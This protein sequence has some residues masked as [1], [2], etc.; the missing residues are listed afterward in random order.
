MKYHLIIILVCFLA[1]REGYSQ[2]KISEAR[3]EIGLFN[4]SK[5]AAILQPLASASG[6]KTKQEAALL[7]A[8]CY[9]M[10]NDLANAKIWYKNALENDNHQLHASIQPVDWYY[11]AQAARSCGEYTLAKSLFLHFDSLVPSDGRGRRFAGFCDSVLAWQAAKPDF[12]VRNLGTLNSPQS[13]FGAVLYKDGV[14]FVSDRVGKKEPGKTYGWT[15]N[16]YLGLYMAKPLV[17]DSLAG[18]YAEPGTL[19]DIPGHEWHEGPVSFN[20]DFSE[21]FI[22]RTLASHDKGKKETGHVR[23]HLLKIFISVRKNGQWQ[24]PIPFFLNSD[25]YSVGHPSL[26]PDGQTL[27]FVSDMKGG[28]GETDIWYCTREGDH[29]S[30]PHNP[31]AAVNTPGKEM[32]PFAAPNGDLYFASD[33]WPGFG[34]LDIFVSHKTNDHRTTARNLGQPV[35][36]SGDDFSM[37]VYDS[38]GNGFFSS[39]RPGGLG[40]DDIYAVLKIPPGYPAPPPPPSNNKHPCLAVTL[41]PMP[42]TLVVDKP[43][44]LPTI[45][46][47]FDKWDIREDAKKPLD[48]LVA[49]MKKYPITIELGSHTDCRGSESYNLLLSQ[50]RAESAVRYIISQGI[51]S[52]R[53]IAKGYGETQ[54]AN[55][56]NCAP[57]VRCSE[58]EHQFNRRTEFTIRKLTY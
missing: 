32:F 12:T 18:A 39:N 58:A 24:E 44:R 30:E 29:W 5:A 36:S 54:P 40:S 50:K 43:Y 20:N 27:Y 55:A 2:D 14:I 13:D 45:F 11:Y 8:G 7:L 25:D 34:G 51:T 33:G 23:T 22:T 17:K 21:L 3:R 52:E 53:I 35:N 6:S 56:C 48:Q 42:D 10:L 4:Y 16:S 37:A 38:A 19:P 31:G 1:T 47:N 9:R 49:L 41:T 15:G 57:G 26:S 28:M 46:Y